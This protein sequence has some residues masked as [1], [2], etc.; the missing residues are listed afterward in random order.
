[1]LEW[2]DD[3]LTQEFESGQIRERVIDDPISV[4][5]I[6]EEFEWTPE[7]VR[8]R[9]TWARRKHR[10]RYIDYTYAPIRPGGLIVLIDPA[11]PHLFPKAETSVA[12][13]KVRTRNTL[14]TLYDQAELTTEVGKLIRAPRMRDMERATHFI[15]T[16][17][18]A[19]EDVL[20]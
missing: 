1:M 16:A 3:W 6:A 8:S 11:A 4:C 5:G 19:M 12:F 2:Q 17:L 10:E 13:G 7:R 20:A 15:L 18:M 14:R 9:L